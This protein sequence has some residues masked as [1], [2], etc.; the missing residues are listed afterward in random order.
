[1]QPNNPYLPPAAAPGP[2]FPGAQ[3]P[4]QPAP[5]NPTAKDPKAATQKRNPSSTQNTLQLSEIRD[6]MVVMADGTFRAVI[7]CNSINYDLMSGNER[8]GVE[9]AYQNFLNALKYP[10]QILI[11]SQR[12]DV[13]PYLDNLFAIRQAQDNMLLNVLMDDYMNF[14]EALSQNA[15]IMDKSFFIVIP[16]S[17]F[18][19]SQN[20]VTQSKGFFGSIFAPKKNTITKIDKPTYEK[21]KEEI[22]RRVESVSAGIRQMGISCRQLNTKQL[23]ELYYNYYNPDTAVNEPLVD[24]SNVATMYVR[25][26]PSG[27]GSNV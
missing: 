11:R 20:L 23:S 5:A 17:G 26:A 10:V 15:N 9:Y 6:D 8:S 12:I 25:Q 7:A 14:V 2:A 4:A 1:M 19:E 13:G 21:A 22:G 16:Y 18:E 27:G 24:F 3:P